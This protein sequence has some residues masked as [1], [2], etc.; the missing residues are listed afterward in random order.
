MEDGNIVTQV[1]LPVSLAFRAPLRIG[2]LPED[3]V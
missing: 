1:L 2:E 3:I